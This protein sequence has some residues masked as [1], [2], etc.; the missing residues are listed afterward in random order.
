MW[1]SVRQGEFKWIYNTEEEADY[2][3]NSE[4]SYELCVLKKYA[5]PLLKK[6]D[7]ENEYYIEA[8]RLIKF[9]KYFIEIDESMVPCDSLLR[10][11]IGGSCFKD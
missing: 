10:E 3:F 11:F 9:L 7:K 5:L 6:I 2:V 1:E 4:L 8:N